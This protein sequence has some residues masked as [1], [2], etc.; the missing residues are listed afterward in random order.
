MSAS[1][2]VTVFAAYGHTGR[3][4]VAELLRRGWHPVLAG[5]DA[6]RLDAMAADYPALERRVASIEDRESLTRALDGAVAVLNCAGPFLDTASAVIDA[7]LAAGIP[8]LDTAA[9]QQAVLQ[10][11]D[12]Y[13]DAARQANIIVL[14]GM[15]FYGGLADLLATAAMGDWPAAEAID[16]GIA[17]DSWHPTRGTRITGQRNHYRRQVIADG[18]LVDIA[19]PAPTRDWSFAGPFGTQPMVELPFSETILISRHLRVRELHGYLNL[20]PLQD[21]RDASTP[22]PLAVD[23]ER[24]SAQRF[25]IE[26]L[27]RSGGQ[28]RR[29]AASGQDIY[30]VSAPLMVEAMERMLDGRCRRHGV[31]AAGEAFDAADFLSALA[32][33]RLQVEVSATREPATPA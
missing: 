7:A 32:P 5:R 13:A 12:R 6:V 8:Y 31:L 11:F 4:V 20:R 21:L 14:P 3:F 2:R 30:A 18:R 16:V 26:V 1:R 27:V 23:P 19:D 17:L 22:P 15:A 29:A 10:T 28:E 9:E 33:A 24:R 25:A